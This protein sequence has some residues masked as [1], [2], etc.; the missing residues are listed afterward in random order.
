MMQEKYTKRY[1]LGFTYKCENRGKTEDLYSKFN[2]VLSG[3]VLKKRE[4]RAD[5]RSVFERLIGY[6]NT[7]STLKWHYI[8]A[9]IYELL[10]MVY[11]ELSSENPK[12]DMDEIL[13]DNSLMRSYRIDMILNKYYMY[14][15]SAAFIAAKLY[16]S[17]KQ[18]NR[19]M[20]KQYKQ[21]FG[22][23]IPN[24][25][26]QVAARYLSETSLCNSEI[27]ARVGYTS[28]CGFYTAFEKQCGCTPG[29][30]RKKAGNSKAPANH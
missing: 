23:K 30:F 10:I 21:T 12:A 27:A 16:L 19:I 17:E 25:R 20:Y 18:V 8:K 7:S 2:S 5:M 24:P 13:S 9:C 4:N 22:Q 15:I 28:L 6:Y 14:D 3:T 11:D 1:S 29:E 26:M